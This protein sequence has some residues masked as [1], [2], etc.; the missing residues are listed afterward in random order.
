MKENKSYLNIRLVDVD[1]QW[2][3][4]KGRSE[5]CASGTI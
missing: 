3:R 1:A 4:S 5:L 2:R